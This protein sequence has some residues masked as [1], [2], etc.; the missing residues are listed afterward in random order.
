MTAERWQQI[1]ELFHAALACEA[2]ARAEFLAT[3]CPNDKLLRHEVESLLSALG[4]ADN[5]IETPAG[6]VAAEML[7]AH[8]SFEPGQQI[9]NYRIVRK[10]GSGGMGEVYLANDTR[11]NRKI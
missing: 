10:L 4:E 2:S 1:D 8:Q 5:F 9:E 11:L 3:Q 6:D 7:G